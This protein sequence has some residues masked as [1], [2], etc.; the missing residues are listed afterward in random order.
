MQNRIMSKKELS[1]YFSRIKPTQQQSIPVDFGN[2]EA[3][4]KLQSLD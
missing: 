3:E 1:K 4:S 2:H